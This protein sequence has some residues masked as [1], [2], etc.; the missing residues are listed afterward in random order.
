[1]DSTKQDDKE[2]HLEESYKDVGGSNHETDDTKDGGNGT[3]HNGKSK[4][5]EAVLYFIIRSALTIKIVVRYVSRKINRKSNTHNQIYH[6]YRVQV[7]APHCHEAKHTQLN[8]NDGESHPQRTDG[9]GYED[10][11]DNHH[12]DSRYQHT[13]HRCRQN[14]QELIKV[15]EV[16][17]KYGDVVLGVVTDLS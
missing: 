6:R 3:L 10:E 4:S 17:M 14:Y 13:L 9:I 1:V 15:D 5:V 2:D 7:D 11:R 12:D 16:G 8:R